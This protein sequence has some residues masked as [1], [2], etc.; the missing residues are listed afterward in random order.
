MCSAV[1]R[2]VPRLRAWTGL[3]LGSHGSC[4]VA[5]H[6]SAR[7]SSAQ[8][9][10]AASEP[11]LGAL[12]PRE[13]EDEAKYS[14]NR[15]LTLSRPT[16]ERTV[17][18]IRHAPALF[19]L[20][21]GT[22]CAADPS[23][24]HDAGS[25]QDAEPI[26]GHDADVSPDAQVLDAEPSLDATT[27]EDDRLPVHGYRVVE[28]DRVLLWRTDTPGEPVGDFMDL[29][30]DGR[31]DILE[32]WRTRPAPS[33]LVVRS[34]RDG[35]ELRRFELPVARSGAVASPAAAWAV[36]DLDGDEIPDLV[37][38]AHVDEGLDEDRP[39]SSEDRLEFLFGL[40]GLDGRRLWELSGA[41]GSAFT[42]VQSVADLDADGIPD[43]LVTI[44][45]DAVTTE[46]AHVRVM[47]GHDGS[48]VL[49]LAPPIDHAWLLQSAWAIE[50]D[51]MTL[52][53]GVSEPESVAGRFALTVWTASST[54]PRWSHV[55]DYGFGAKLGGLIDVNG[56]GT[57]DP[58]LVIT[59][60][61]IGASAEVPW[62]LVM[63]FDGTSG[64][65]LWSSESR[66]VLE[67]RLGT[68]FAVAPDLNQDGSSEL[69]AGTSQAQVADSPSHFVILDG[70]T[71]RYLA[72]VV[73]EYFRT[74][75]EMC[76]FGERLSAF[77]DPTARGGVGV[78]VT[79]WQA[80][81][82]LLAAWS[83]RP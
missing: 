42:N 56:D 20:T 1:L 45:P 40:S 10:H 64:Q 9:M 11:I 75:P 13:V 82:Q 19:L 59:E 67:G 3:G 30:G 43:L 60:R 66:N 29:D 34:G 58:I 61:P 7:G 24:S 74:F 31:R 72:E 80:G 27:P 44:V 18:I 70:T 54:T 38:R 76:R 22:G 35:Q 16:I 55:E 81:R 57:P 65:L 25:P 52:V 6:G 47:S 68:G 21:F 36:P 15:E 12:R 14:V 39:V 50:S 37:V 28:G 79:H 4:A 8:N 23:S 63:S 73:Y 26:S 78:A 77:D 46:R 62:G 17:M 33:R 32:L 41:P 51:P 53:A 83:C 69:L 71:G 2:G 5:R 49:T 48:T